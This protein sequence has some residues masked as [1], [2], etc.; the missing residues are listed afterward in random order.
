M[1]FMVPARIRLDLADGTLCL[2]DEVRMQLAGRKPPYRST[3]QAITAN[4][5]HV[6]MSSGGS[7]EVKNGIGLP[8]SKLWVTRDPNWVP[9][10]ITGPGRIK[11]LQLTNLI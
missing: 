8:N 3:M 9:K 4:D 7:A 5:Q 10:V 2:P 11:Y 6:I 1:D